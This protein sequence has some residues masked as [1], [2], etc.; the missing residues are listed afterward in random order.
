MTRHGVR[1]GK[2]L[3]REGA[4]MDYRD[5]TDWKLHQELR[6]I[7]LELLSRGA[8][9]QVEYGFIERGDGSLELGPI[10]VLTIPAPSQP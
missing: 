1:A 2:N 5:M 3:P 6:K 9:V 8:P 10:T 4:A 7:Q